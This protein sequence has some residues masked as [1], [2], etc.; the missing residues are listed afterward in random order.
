MTRQTR[1]FTSGRDYRPAGF[2]GGHLAPHAIYARV[3]VSAPDVSFA[4][5][6]LNGQQLSRYAET[7]REPTSADAPAR[8]VADYVRQAGIDETA[9]FVLYRLDTD[10]VGAPLP[11]PQFLLDRLKGGRLTTVGRVRVVSMGRPTDPEP[12]AQVVSDDGSTDPVP[13][14]ATHEGPDGPP[15]EGAVAFPDG[16]AGERARLAEGALAEGLAR[17]VQEITHIQA[18]VA[19]ARVSGDPRRAVNRESPALAALSLTLTELCGYATTVEEA[20]TS[21]DNGGCADTP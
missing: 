7:L 19:S 16:P 17:A 3:L 10:T 20:L 18:A 14:P 8:A 4:E 2:W 12:I 1:L 6:A 13:L 9:V 5:E 11:A 21:P 15:I